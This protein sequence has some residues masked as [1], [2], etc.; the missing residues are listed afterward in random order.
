MKWE[1]ALFFHCP[2]RGLG[3]SS[4][5]FYGEN[6]AHFG[7]LMVDFM[8]ML[9]FWDRKSG[10]LGGKYVFLGEIMVHSGCFGK[11]LWVKSC[12][13]ESENASPMGAQIIE[14]P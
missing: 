3:T 12:C 14:K 2:C 1:R 7:V 8:P 9:V 5:C 10:L 11:E 6:D 4:G 13:T